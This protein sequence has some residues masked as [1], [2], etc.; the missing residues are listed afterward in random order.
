MEFG[1]VRDLTLPKLD[2]CVALVPK[3]VDSLPISLSVPL[4]LLEPE[5]PVS[6]GNLR[7]CAL[8]VV[9]PKAAVNENCPPFGFICQIWTSRQA[10]H[11]DA[12]A[13]SEIV[14]DSTDRAFRSRSPSPYVR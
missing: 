8:L 11:V 3:P 9:V 4:E 1:Q 10:T 12:V 5:L 13:V 6:L 7:T 2:H 14:D